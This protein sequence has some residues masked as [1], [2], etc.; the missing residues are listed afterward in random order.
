M[1]SQGGME[2]SQEAGGGFLG[3][4][5]W[6]AV[7]MRNTCTTHLVKKDI[8]YYN[9]RGL[10]YSICDIKKLIINQNKQVD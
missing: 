6:T 1:S 9:L 7:V 2:R 5:V 3:D 10:A 4:C 8:F